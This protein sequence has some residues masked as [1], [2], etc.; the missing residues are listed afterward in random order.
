MIT[1]AEKVEVEELY[2]RKL[3]QSSHVD[4]KQK[5]EYIRKLRG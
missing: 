5:E 1:I 4:Q 3:L 2:Y